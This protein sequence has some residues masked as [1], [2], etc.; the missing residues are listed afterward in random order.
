MVAMLDGISPVKAFDPNDTDMARTIPLISFGTGPENKL[1]ST[2]KSTIF[3]N[4]PISDGIGP[5]NLQLLM[6]NDV[7]EVSRPI[8]EGRA[9]ESRSLSLNIRLSR[10]WER[11][12]ISLTNEYVS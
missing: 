7:R 6:S 3:D 12:P 5:E 2:L 11:I 8:S 4:R 1:L 10:L 9:P